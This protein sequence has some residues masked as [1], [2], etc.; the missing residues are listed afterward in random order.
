MSKYVAIDTYCSDAMNSWPICSLSAPLISLL[1]NTG[2]SPDWMKWRVRAATPPIASALRFFLEYLHRH[3]HEP[4]QL[5]VRGLRKQRFGPDVMLRAAVALEQSP[6][7]REQGNALQLSA[8]LGVAAILRAAHRRL[9]AL[10]VAQRLR[11]E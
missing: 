10:C 5:V 3:R 9:E 1:I 11:R 6:D 4:I 8:P 2:R 7:E